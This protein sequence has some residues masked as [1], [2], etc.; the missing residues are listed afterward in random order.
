MSATTRVECYNILT[1]LCHL[2]HRHISAAVALVTLPHGV[3]VVTSILA[4]FSRLRSIYYTSLLLSMLSVSQVL[5]PLL[6]FQPGDD[7]DIS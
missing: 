4:S 3:R 7:I 6:Q 1:V 2:L 5:W